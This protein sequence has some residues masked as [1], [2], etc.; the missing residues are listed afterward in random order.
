MIALLRTTLIAWLLVASVSTALGERNKLKPSDF[1]PLTS[2]PW[3]QPDATP[4]SVLDAIFREPNP[5][6][7]YPVLAEYLR[8][9]PVGQLGKAFDLCVDLEGT[10]TPDDFAEFF[11]PIWAKRDPN[12]CWKRTKELFHVVGIDEGW[13]AYDSWE[14]RPRITVQDLGAIRASRFW[15]TRAALLSFPLGLAE[16]SLP[17]E[18]RVSIMKEF[19]VTWFS[20]FSSWPGYPRPAWGYSYSRAY[21]DFDFSLIEAFGKSVAE[22]QSYVKN[23]D[24]QGSGTVYEGAFIVAARRWLQAKPASAP[25]ILERVGKKK[26]PPAQNPCGGLIELLMLWA[27]ADL[28]AMIEWVESLDLGKDDFALT[29][30]GFLMSRVDAETRDRWLAEAKLDNDKLL[31]LL[32]NW[33]GWDPRSALDVALATNDREIIE[34]V[35]TTAYH[36][37]WPGQSWNTC[38]FGLGVMKDFDSR[39]LPEAYRKDQFMNWEMIMETWGDVD[40]GEAARYGLDFL[41]RNDYAPREKLIQFFGGADVLA[42]TGDVIDRT[43]C[44]LRVWAVFKPDEM[45]TWIAT[46]DDAEMR[47]ALTWLLQHPW[48]N[49]P[50]E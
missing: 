29:G 50:K 15:I 16:S 27:R 21:P 41:L 3:K 44:A 30:R 32:H 28:P 46:L 45:K 19:A 5:A 42:D 8:M 38:H 6:I 23:A 9:I 18:E 48:G 17:K 25:E 39:R 22:T 4:E 31:G 13:L 35:A 26:W 2:L 33:A 1:E 10:Q 43:F 24:T 40:I 49:G 14:K 36:G 12:G 11:L 47:K 7:R 34:E 20:A 37:P